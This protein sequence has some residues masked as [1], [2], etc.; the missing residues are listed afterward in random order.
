MPTNSVPIVKKSSSLPTILIAGGAGF[1]GSHL[2]E[3]LLETQCRIVAI[4]NLATGRR[5]FI[6]PLTSH[7]RFTFIDANINNRLPKE[8]ESVNYVFHL[9]ALEVYLSGRKE[10]SLDTLLTNALGTKN[11]LSLAKKSNAKFLLASSIDVYRGLLSSQNLE[12]YFGA[13]PEEERRFAHAEAK[14]FAEA[15]VWESFETDKLNARIVR[16]GEI[17]GPRMHLKSSGTLGRLLEELLTGQ[18]LTVYGEGLEKEYYT[19]VSDVVR[20]I[21]EAA[22]STNTTGKIYPVTTLE[23]TTPLELVYLLKEVVGEDLRVIFKPPLEKTLLAEPKVID[24]EQQRELGWEP[25]ISLKEGILEVLKEQ[26]I[27]VEEKPATTPRRRSGQAVAPKLIPEK[28]KKKEEK[29]KEE[30]IETKMIKLSQLWERVKEKKLTRAVPLAAFLA[31]TYF[32]FFPGL[33]LALNSYSGYRK[34]TSFKQNLKELNLEKAEEN[35]LS[36]EAN[37]KSAGR[38]LENLSWLLSLARQGR[39]KKSLAHLFQAGAF[40]SSALGYET[41]G[42]KPLSDAVL[43]LVAQDSTELQTTNLNEAA[44]A[45]TEAQEKI[46]L[47]EAHLKKAD[48]KIFGGRLEKYYLLL[49]N[50]T[51]GLKEATPMIKTLTT[52]LPEIL[53]AESPKTYLLIF[54]NSNELRPTGGFIGSYGKLILSKG[55]IDRLV[56]DDVYNLDG[57]LETKGIEIEP[58]EPLKEHLG[59]SRWLLRDANWS[60]DFP[61]ASEQI[62]NLYSLATGGK[63]DGIIALDLELVQKLLGLTGSVYLAQFNESIG[64]ENFFEKTE[65]YSEADYFSGSPQ[66]KTFLSLLSAKLLE[67]ILKLETQDFGRLGQIIRNSLTERHLLIYFPEGEVANLLALKNWDGRIRTSDGDYLMVVD[68]NVG[69]TKANYYVKRNLNYA[70]KN[71]DRQGTWEATSTINYVHGAASNTWPG[72]AYKNYVRIYVPK[73][74]VLKK[75][76]RSS[77]G[78]DTKALDITEEIDQTEESG[79]TVWG[80]VFTLNAGKSLSLTFTYDLPPEK[81]LDLKTNSYSLLVQK[82]PGTVADPLTVDF[83]TPF[84]RTLVE[85]PEGSKRIGDLWR[86]SGNLREDRELLYVLE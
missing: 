69:A 33:S 21:V 6:Q 64:A 85:A 80:T 39:A 57:L 46:L 18:D 7:P 47:A 42:V 77:E 74:C 11:L 8:I 66:K 5:S 10:I 28:E 58:P 35:A 62:R 63:V 56:V 19:H 34:L 15:L 27:E 54:Q 60:P 82:Q 51:A 68:T 86:Y 16:L 44:A 52:A 50:T 14:R 45:L 81:G 12:D 43:N 48:P 73:G 36:A 84:G 26:R 4:D 13:T 17:Y 75:V 40:L 79:K 41:R 30:K 29:K 67:K 38:N 1:L 23:P 78:V 2:A 9:A 72:G 83:L 31:L 24:G 71:V 55:Q 37:L 49:E 61:T 76:A 32:A 65:F 20:G 59:V 25:K 53:G 70:I 3:K 22:F